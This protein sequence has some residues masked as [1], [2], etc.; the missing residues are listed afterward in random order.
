MG[1]A[2]SLP[3]EDRLLTRGE[4]AAE[5]GVAGK[6][7]VR[8]AEEGKL[9]AVRTLGGHRRYRAVEVAGLKRKRARKAAKAAAGA[10]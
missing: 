10:G 8:W 1:K 3:E 2:R 6:T 5:L 4:A 7:P 9:T